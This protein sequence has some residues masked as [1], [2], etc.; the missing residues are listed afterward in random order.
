MKKYLAYY[1]NEWP[2]NIAE[3]TA[4]ENKPFVGYLK[5]EGVSF[6]V[7]PKV[8]PDNEIWYTTVDG[9][10]LNLHKDYMHIACS[11]YDSENKYIDKSYD[12]FIVSNTYNN[13][14]GI[15]KFDRPITEIQAGFF[16]RYHD[17]MGDYITTY[18]LKTITL[19]K[20]VKRIKT[21]A[22]YKCCDLELVTI[23]QG[24]EKIDWGAFTDSGLKY[25]NLPTSL[26]YLHSS[27][28]VGTPIEDDE[29]YWENGLMY[30]DNCLIT[31]DPHQ[32]SEIIIRPGTFLIAD[33]AQRDSNHN[34]YI[35]RLEIPES[36]VYNCGG[37]TNFAY[38]CEADNFHNSSSLQID[39]YDYHS[40]RIEG[41]I[42]VDHIENGACITDGIVV[43]IIEGSNNVVIPNN[44]TGFDRRFPLTGYNLSG[45][46]AFLGTMEEWSALNNL[47][48]FGGPCEGFVEFDYIQCS[49][50]QITIDKSGS[51]D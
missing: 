17:G 23:Q 3:L 38:V 33:G 11:E 2:A 24:L 13:G 14:I 28:F 15:I 21:C 47:P 22:F 16:N 34:H 1:E 35:S 8:Q 29:T 49:D 32:T 9:N 7:I 20:S 41:L 36:V 42:L 5:G 31:I 25:I 18:N 44:I 26:N 4:V 37:S 45:T 39:I 30:I 10:S 51:C 40:G 19:P 12:V 43:W 48:Y 6:T 27:A 50:G 46:F